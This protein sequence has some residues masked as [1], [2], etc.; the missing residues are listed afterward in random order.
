[1]SPNSTSS[2]MRG[3]GSQSSGVTDGTIPTNLPRD[4][5]PVPG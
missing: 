2:T 3:A 4:P 5:N 1:M